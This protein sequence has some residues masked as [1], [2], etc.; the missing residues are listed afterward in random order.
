MQ[1]RVLSNRRREKGGEPPEYSCPL[2]G[3]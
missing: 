1:S 3:K 2:W